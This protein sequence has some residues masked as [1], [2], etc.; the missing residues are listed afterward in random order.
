MLFGIRYKNNDKGLQ[1]VNYCMQK[2]GCAFITQGKCDLYF[3]NPFEAFL[4]SRRLTKVH[5]NL[6]Y[7]IFVP[8]AEDRK[9]IPEEKIVRNRE[10]YNAIMDERTKELTELLEKQKQFEQQSQE[11]PQK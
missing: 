5:E 4:M 9:K 7:S 8:S 6:T 3:T 10:E 11:E 2:Y 1:I